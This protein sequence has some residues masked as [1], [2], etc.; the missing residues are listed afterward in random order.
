[1]VLKDTWID[2]D[3]MREGDILAS[4]RETA[5]PEGKQ[6]LEKYFLTTICHGDVQTELNVVDDTANALM[7]GLEIAKDHAP[8][9]RL[10]QGPN[11]QENTSGTGSANL[12][13]SPAQIPS[14]RIRYAP[15]THYRIVFREI[16]T[17]IDRLQSLPDVMKVLTET[18]SGAF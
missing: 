5:D 18:V 14:D 8:L 9:F 15:K 6:L 11:I 3:R 13:A 17:T 4:L 12:R 7:R 10:Q 2:S 16:G 1:M